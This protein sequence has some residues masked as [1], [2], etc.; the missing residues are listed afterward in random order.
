[1]SRVR[2]YTRHISETSR[3]RTVCFGNTGCKH[4]FLFVYKRT[5]QGPFN[6]FNLTVTLT[7]GGLVSLY[8]LNTTQLYFLVH[9]YSNMAPINPLPHLICY[10][11]AVYLFIWSDSAVIIDQALFFL[12]AFIFP[13]RG[14]SLFEE[15]VGSRWTT[16]GDVQVLHQLL[17][18]CRH[19]NCLLQLAIRSQLKHSRN[20]RD[21]EKQ[22]KSLLRRSKE[23]VLLIEISSREK[24]EMMFCEK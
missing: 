17:V 2:K 3:V 16:V 10:Y 4:H 13:N 9:T 5:P 11:V 22:M 8:C 21:G 23:V 12:A 6:L 7:L 19:G 18:V 24:L 20:L 15:P 14:I 1:M